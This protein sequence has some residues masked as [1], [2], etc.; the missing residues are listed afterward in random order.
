MYNSYLMERA[1]EKSN[2]ISE[3]NGTNNKMRG[4]P[5]FDNIIWEEQYEQL[6]LDLEGLLQIVIIDTSTALSREIHWLSSIGF[7]NIYPIKILV[8]DRNEYTREYIGFMMQK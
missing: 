5:V 4:V 6:G 1:V 8:Q 2:E 3:K 7:K